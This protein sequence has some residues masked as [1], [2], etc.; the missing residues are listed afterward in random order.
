MRQTEGHEGP[1]RACPRIRPEPFRGDY[2]NVT[3]SDYGVYSLGW[4]PRLIVHAGHQAVEQPTSAKMPPVV[5]RCLPHGPAFNGAESLRRSLEAKS[6]ASARPPATAV[7]RS[8]GERCR[9][10]PRGH[11]RVTPRRRLRCEAAAGRR[12]SSQPPDE[13]RG[14][15][16]YRRGGNGV[17][18]RLPSEPAGR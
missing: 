2:G 7:S 12:R 9:A 3:K 17:P 16:D 1:Q 15:Q 10:E 14:K 11:A 6:A 8:A 13:H 5:D 18:G 4:G